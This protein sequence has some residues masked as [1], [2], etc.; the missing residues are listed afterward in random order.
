M[1]VNNCISVCL[2]SEIRIEQALK[3]AGVEDPNSVEKLIIS[4]E[5]TGDDFFF[6]SC[7]KN[8]QAFDMGDAII[9]EDEKIGKGRLGFL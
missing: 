4:G 2:T 1:T 6:I 5:A 7:M 8:L 3:E 9:G